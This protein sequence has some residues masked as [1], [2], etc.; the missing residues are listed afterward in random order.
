MGIW[1]RRIRKGVKG[2][3]L[4]SR[5]ES[6]RFKRRLEKV[7]KRVTHKVTVSNCKLKIPQEIGK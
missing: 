6:M 7:G 5:R 3:K 1:N 4:W 2:I